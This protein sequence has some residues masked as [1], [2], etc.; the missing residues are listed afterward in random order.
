MAVDMADMVVVL[1]MLLQ[2]TVVMAEAMV[3]NIFHYHNRW[4]FSINSYFSGY[5]AGYGG[6]GYGRGYG[7]KFFI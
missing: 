1:V 2:S 7:G 4:S 6:L 5:G 3:V